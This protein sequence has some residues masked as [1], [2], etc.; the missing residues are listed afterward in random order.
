M[1]LP[2]DY[3]VAPLKNLTF[4]EQALALLH[5]LEDI[6]IRFRYVYGGV[7]MI[8]GIVYYFSRAESDTIEPDDHNNLVDFAELYLE[9]L[10]LVLRKF[11]YI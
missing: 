3:H 5:R 11:G 2:K 8:N 9:F 6:Y 4:Y 10:K 7:T 1:A